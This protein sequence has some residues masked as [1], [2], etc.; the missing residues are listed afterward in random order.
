VRST[1]SG[2]K[3]DSTPAATVAKIPNNGLSQE[4]A[5]NLS[6]ENADNAA[7][8]VMGSVCM[9]S[10]ERIVASATV[11]GRAECAVQL[12][13]VKQGE[14]NRRGIKDARMAGRL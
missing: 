13:L 9:T 14:Q 4:Q 8:T 10:A 1:S 6:S 3:D 2:H 5:L 7:A 11:L 12:T